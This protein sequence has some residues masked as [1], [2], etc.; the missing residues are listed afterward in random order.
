MKTRDRILDTALRLFNES[1][2]AAVTTNHI[3][4]ALGMSPGNLYY[5]F[6]NKDEIIRALF[7]QLFAL[8]D[9]LFDLPPDRAPTLADIERL[10]RANFAVTFDYRFIYRE[11]IAL[12]RRD[13]LLGR[14]WVEIRTRGFAGFRELIDG[15]GAAGVIVAPHDDDELTRIAELCWLVSEFWPANV[16]VSGKALDA[17]QVER[18]IALLLQVLKPYIVA[19]DI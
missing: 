9:Q 2:T 3:A 17:A 5:H 13:Q 10:V 19:S 11:L 6:R 7:E 18:G 1:G 16:E 8:W 4:D 15:F 14:R 12:L